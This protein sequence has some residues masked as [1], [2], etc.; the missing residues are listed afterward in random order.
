MAHAI[1]TTLALLSLTLSVAVFLHSV[2]VAHLV[3]LVTT[4]GKLDAKKIVHHDD[5]RP[6]LH[7]HHDKQPLSQL[8]KTFGD[9]ANLV[10]ARSHRLLRRRHR[11]HTFGIDRFKQWWHAHELIA[12]RL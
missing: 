6:D 3:G 7:N 12:I 9:H 10:H 1:K 5:V 4:D 11:T 2:H 8:L